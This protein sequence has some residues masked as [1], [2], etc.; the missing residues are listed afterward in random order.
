MAL[1]AVNDPSVF[2][3]KSL[4]KKIFSSVVYDFAKKYVTCFGSLSRQTAFDAFWS[5]FVN[6]HPFES[7]LFPYKGRDYSLKAQARSLFTNFLCSF[8]AKYPDKYSS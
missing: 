1:L 4:E 3:D 8:R 7:Q 2:Q 5:Q 6:L